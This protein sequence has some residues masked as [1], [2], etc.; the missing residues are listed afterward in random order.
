MKSAQGRMGRVFVLRLED[1]DR[2]PD[3]IESFAQDN[4]IAQAFCAVLG[5]IGSGKL[6]TG[7]EEPDASPIN[8]LIT[9]F[10]SVHEAAAVGTLFLDEAGEPKLHMHA[11][12]GRDGETKTGCIRQGIKVWKVCEVVILELLDLGLMR[13]MDKASGF[14]MLD[15][16]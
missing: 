9:S 6:V 15:E 5:G 16:V 1:G 2:L 3:S 11:A 8:P 10:G 14:E 7:P 13:K 4:G 12:L